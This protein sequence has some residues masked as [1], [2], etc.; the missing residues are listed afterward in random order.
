MSRKNI[1]IL[2]ENNEVR[3]SISQISREGMSYLQPKFECFNRQ[4]VFLFSNLRL[5]LIL[6]LD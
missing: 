1:Q 3:R 4:V 2:S 5:D 6:A